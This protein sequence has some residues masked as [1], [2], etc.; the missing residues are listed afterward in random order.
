MNIIES[1]HEALE[2]CKQPV[3]SAD[4][5]LK[6]RLSIGVDYAI[7][8]SPNDK[9]SSVAQNLAQKLD[10]GDKKLSFYY[11]GQKL[12]HNQLVSPNWV[13]FVHVFVFSSD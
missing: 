5:E 3:L 6:F 11:L 12:T 4:F 8:V 10:L 1:S 13:S 9:L 7:V 2:A